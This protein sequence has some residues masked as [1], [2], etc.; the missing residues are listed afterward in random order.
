M[1]LLWNSS[2][3]EVHLSVTPGD[4]RYSVSVRTQHPFWLHH[5]QTRHLRIIITQHM[6]G[7][8][9]IQNHRQ[10]M[11]YSSEC[12]RLKRGVVVSHLFP[13]PSVAI[14]TYLSHSI[15]KT[16]HSS[17]THSI[18]ISDPDNIIRS[19]F[20][21]SMMILPSTM[22]YHVDLC[23]ILQGQ[24]NIPPAQGVQPHNTPLKTTGKCI[25]CRFQCLTFTIITWNQ[26]AMIK[27]E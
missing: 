23:V 20:F 16:S 9:E 5:H 6:Q 12:H 18:H 3:L 27:T 17:K 24:G 1:L 25:A 7:S 4:L 11:R 2:H 14:Q 8:L 21:W 26:L 22:Y 15:K 19:D 13:Q 10:Q